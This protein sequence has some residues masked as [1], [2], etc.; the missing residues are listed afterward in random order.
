MV[1]N[2]IKLSRGDHVYVGSPSGWYKATVVAESD[3]EVKIHYDGLAEIWDT[4]V[5]RGSLRL[6]KD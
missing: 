6:K 5:N 1:T 4:A 2:A 3:A